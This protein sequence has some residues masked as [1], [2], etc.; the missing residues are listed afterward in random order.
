MPGPPTEQAR[1]VHT[2]EKKKNTIMYAIKRSLAVS[3]ALPLLTLPLMLGVAGCDKDKKPEGDA[4][5]EDAK[6]AVEK[7]DPATLFTGDKVT[8]P[9]V[10][11]TVTLGMTQEQAKAAMP[12]LPEDGTI[13]TEEYPDLRFNTDFDD[14]SKKLTRVYFSLPKADA[15]KF[16][17]E[18]WGEP[19]KG[20]DLG[21]EVLW[22]FNP[23]AGLRVSIA[24]SFSEGEVYVEFTSYIPVKQFLGEGKELAFA[25]DAPLLGLT[26]ADLEAKYPAFLKKESEE[27]AK[28]SQ[29]DLAKFAGDEVKAVLGKPTASVDL[30]Y[31]PTEWAK[32]WTPVHLS[33]SDEG[34]IERFW[35]GI[36]FEPH[37]AAKDELMAFF[38]TKWG[39]PTEEDEY[40]D[41]LFV[42]SQ[43]P[44]IEVKEDTISNKWDITVELPKAP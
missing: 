31:L 33:W 24:D 37:P 29:E 17:T 36:D 18:K 28:K 1:P 11:G 13:K 16:A 42:F 44:R 12:T 25:K 32:Y 5:T 38:K 8:M 22:W 9:A 21:K 39:E 30:E 40:G 34:K 7:K 43:D 20:T 26:V 3:L 4:K 41:K 14:D 35:F 15:I 2:T 23:E 27:E 10:F 6:P 19:K